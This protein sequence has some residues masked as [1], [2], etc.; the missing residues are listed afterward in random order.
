MAD[1]QRLR[2]DP[3]PAIHPVP[4]YAA[5]A[6]LRERYRDMKTVLQVPWMGVVTMVYAH[7]R[8]FYDA[9]WRG[10]RPLCASAPFIDAAMSLRAFTE[11]QVDALDASS[12][13]EALRD[14]GYG[15]RE[16]DGIRQVNEIFSHGNFL[17]LLIATL[18]RQLLEGGEK[19]G[20]GEAALFEGRHAPAVDMPLVLM[21]AHHADPPTRAIF[22]DI[23]ATL[24]LPFVNTDYRAF[25]RW[26]SYFHVAWPALKA[27]WPGDV[28]Q[29]VVARVHAR[30][31]ELVDGMPNP[32]NLDGNAVRAAAARD[33]PPEEVLSVCRLFQWLLPGLVTNVAFLRKQL[34]QE[35]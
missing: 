14:A 8:N 5:D 20:G 9:L 11:S 18:A 21:E 26:P 32:G 27:S 19:S 22:D 6:A 31:C 33:A 25:A 15:A 16:L 4:E 35:T 34:T 10:T 2:P 1:M 30:A 7:Y 17:Y 13:V 12:I 28:H 24:E 3:L 23:K 29:S